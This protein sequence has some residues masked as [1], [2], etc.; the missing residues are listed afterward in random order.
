[1]LRQVE[2]QHELAPNGALE[3]PLTALVERVGRN[4]DIFGMTPSVVGPE[5]MLNRAFLLPYG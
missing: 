1:L 3:E 5:W 4:V 2:L